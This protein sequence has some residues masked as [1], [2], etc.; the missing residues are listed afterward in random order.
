MPVPQ[1]IIG[2]STLTAVFPSGSEVVANSTGTQ[3]FT[4]YYQYNDGGNLDTILDTFT[5]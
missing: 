5:R 4:V 1:A 2:T 3:T